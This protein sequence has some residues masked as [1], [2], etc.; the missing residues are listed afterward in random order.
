M[1]IDVNKWMH[2]ISALGVNFV[3]P[4]EEGWD[5]PG[6]EGGKAAGFNQISDID[7]TMANSIN[8]YI[9]LMDKIE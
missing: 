2:Y 8:Q 1:G 7:L 9:M 6:R 5:I 3:N 4:Y